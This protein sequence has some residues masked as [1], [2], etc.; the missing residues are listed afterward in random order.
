M[1]WEDNFQ[2]KS[3]Q[4]TD[5]TVAYWGGR[6][7][8]C[9]RYIGR[10]SRTS[11]GS[12]NDGVDHHWFE[13]HSVVVAYLLTSTRL[14][15]GSAANTSCAALRTE[16]SSP[17]RRCEVHRLFSDRS[18]SQWWPVRSQLAGASV[19]VLV[20]R[21]SRRQPSVTSPPITRQPPTAN[22]V[23]REL[24]Q[25]RRRPI[26]F[27]ACLC[28]CVC[29]GGAGGG[30]GGG[31]K[32]GGVVVL[33]WAALCGLWCV[34]VGSACI[35]ALSS[36]LLVHYITCVS[37]DVVYTVQCTVCSVYSQQYCESN[38]YS[39]SVYTLKCMHDAHKHAYCVHNLRIH[40]IAHKHT[41]TI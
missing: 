37:I 32:G 23:R 24:G 2:T 39:G 16:L 7:L 1:I 25:T 19:N 20:R 34:L 11:D 22:R 31:G 21:A 35:V 38:R 13:P 29:V 6:N 27:R 36:S 30:G 12:S 5:V 33:R 40:I 10:T 3:I 41:H 17:H 26:G 9:R 18:A 15:P 8:L 14:S 4:P 28:V